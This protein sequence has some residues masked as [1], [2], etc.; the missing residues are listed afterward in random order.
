MNQEEINALLRK[1]QHIRKTRDQ[2]MMVL[3]KK[4]FDKMNFI[5]S[6]GVNIAAQ[7]SAIINHIRNTGLSLTTATVDSMLETVADSRLYD[8]CDEEDGKS[9]FENRVSLDLGEE[10]SNL[11]QHDEASIEKISDQQ[12]LP[13]TFLSEDIKQLVTAMD[14]Q[15]EEYCKVLVIPSNNSVKFKESLKECSHAADQLAQQIKSIEDRALENSKKYFDN[16]GDDEYKGGTA[17]L[18]RSIN[19]NVQSVEESTRKL[20]AD[21]SHSRKEFLRMSHL[22]GLLNVAPHHSYEKVRDT[23]A[24]IRRV[25]QKKSNESNHQWLQ[26]EKK[27]REKQITQ[28]RRLYDVYVGSSDPLIMQTDSEEGIQSFESKL[29]EHRVHVNHK[30]KEFHRTVID[31]SGRNIDKITS[32]S[33]VLIAWRNK[34]IPWELQEQRSM[35]ASLALS[36]SAVEDEYNAVVERLRDHLCHV[37]GQLDTLELHRQKL[38]HLLATPVESQRTMRDKS[39]KLHPKVFTPRKSQGGASTSSPVMEDLSPPSNS[40]RLGTRTVNLSKLVSID[41]EECLSLLTQ[42][43]HEIQPDAV[44]MK[45]LQHYTAHYSKLLNSQNAKSESKSSQHV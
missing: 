24:H 3:L 31:I 23:F 9:V 14:N 6:S 22:N 12:H 29:Q 15:L 26:F 32:D 10:S 43:L 16:L 30:L 8:S 42:L 40:A 17:R 25:S 21:I 1:K 19:I 41:N 35:E 38:V 11:T 4:H 45:R 2:T 44:V 5:Q 18:V 39:A 34:V 7:T 37:L 27:C 20:Q 28:M 13:D 36:V 33:D